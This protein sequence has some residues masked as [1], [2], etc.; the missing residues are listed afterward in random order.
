M[1]PSLYSRWLRPELT[2]PSESQPRVIA[3]RLVP[4]HKWWPCSTGDLIAI[5]CWSRQ[6]LVGSGFEENLCW[7]HRTIVLCLIK[8]IVSKM[9]SAAIYKRQYTSVLPLLHH[10]LQ[11]ASF[12]WNLWKGNEFCIFI[13]Q[14][15]LIK[16]AN[17]LLD[18]LSALVL[19]V[20]NWM[21]SSCTGVCQIQLEIWSEPDFRKMARFR[22]CWNWSWKEYVT[23]LKILTLS[24]YLII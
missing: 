18:R 9:L 6:A 23:A 16:T 19:T 24:N 10:C 21:H 22:I 15:T 1:S 13:I 20:I 5:K 2:Q 3:I 8:L 14:V 7:D 17:T 11:L 12:W 4:D